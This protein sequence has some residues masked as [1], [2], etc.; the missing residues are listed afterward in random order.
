[1][2]MFCICKLQHELGPQ[3][4]QIMTLTIKIEH[5]LFGS[6]SLFESRSDSNNNNGLRLSPKWE[7]LLNHGLHRT[8]N[9]VNIKAD[10]TAM[11]TLTKYTYMAFLRIVVFF[12]K[13]VLGEGGAEFKSF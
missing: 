2:V 13:F 5:N 7:E 9:K 8:Q 12:C 4:Y 1:M 10:F 3:M 11:K 6:L